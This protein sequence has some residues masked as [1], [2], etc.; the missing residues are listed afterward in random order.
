MVSFLAA[1][2]GFIIYLSECFWLFFCM[3]FHPRCRNDDLKL[4]EYEKSL[5][6]TRIQLFLPQS[7]PTTATVMALCRFYCL[8]FFCSSIFFP[9]LYWRPSIFSVIACTTRKTEYEK[10]QMRKRGR[11]M[12]LCTSFAIE[13]VGV[14]MLSLCSSP[15]IS[16]YIFHYI[17]HKPL[18]YWKLMLEHLKINLTPSLAQNNSLHFNLLRWIGN[19]GGFGNL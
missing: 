17:V 11:C 2:P 10:L 19:G 6:E 12:P 5:F 1:G 16:S 13:E 9:K 18:L 3:N 8:W 4:K 7:C 14:R 15:W